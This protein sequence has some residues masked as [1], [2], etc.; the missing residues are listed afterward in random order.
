MQPN[1][2]KC[3]HDGVCLVNLSH[4]LLSG[5]DG[6]GMTQDF[7]TPS[8]NAYAAKVAGS[9]ELNRCRRILCPVVRHCRSMSP[10]P[11]GS[12]GE[13]NV[14]DTRHCSSAHFFVPWQNPRSLSQCRER[15]STPNFRQNASNS[16]RAAMMETVS[17]CLI[18]DTQLS[19][20]NWSCSP[21]TYFSPPWT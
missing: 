18:K 20:E 16:P 6:M 5:C 21:R 8:S 7:W 11:V 4:G 15:T 12:F 13:L 2:L 10:F 3:M 14:M 9:R 17:L 19:V 1:G